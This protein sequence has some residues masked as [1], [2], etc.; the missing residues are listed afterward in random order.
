M[1]LIELKAFNAVAEGGGFVRGAE[2]L[3]RAQPTVT[4]QVRALEARHGVELFFRARG[5]AAQLT[6][7]GRLLFE[8]TRSLFKLEEDAE[9]ILS[10]ARGTRE[11]ILR[12]GV[13]APRSAMGLVSRF[14]ERHANRRI[15]M[16]IANSAQVI[17]WLRAYQVDIGILGT[18][19]RD[20]AFYMRRYSKPEIVMLASADRRF[21]RN[22]C[23][24]R[25]A[26]ARETLIVREE[27]SETR[28]LVD[29]ALARHGWRPARQFVIA[30][31]EGVAAAAEAGLGLAPI[32][33]EE[34]DPGSRA[35]VV[36]FE[37]SPSRARCS[38]SA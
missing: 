24:S 3:R 28:S 20:P 35:Q 2:S 36:R 9:A 25:E 29:A 5:Q 33:L 34:I 30:T 14:C 27:G 6:P 12:I 31:R 11:G 19:E 7:I 32:S 26:F 23:V 21:G 4:A 1:S 38:W 15:E 18:H 37:N 16:R 22:G 17:E 13:I 10:G 8:T